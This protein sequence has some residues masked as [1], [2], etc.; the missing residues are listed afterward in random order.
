M[1]SH[2]NA[3]EVNFFC[4]GGHSRNFHIEKR[5]NFTSEKRTCDRMKIE[6]FFKLNSRDSFSDSTLI[7]APENIPDTSCC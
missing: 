1:I 3:C 4:C 6:R 2:V 7:K 5:Y